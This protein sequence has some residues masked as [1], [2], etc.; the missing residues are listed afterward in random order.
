MAVDIKHTNERVNILV[1]CSNNLRHAAKL[2][3]D[4]QKYHD[5]CTDYANRATNVNARMAVVKSL[6]DAIANEL[7]ELASD[8]NMAFQ[9][10]WVAGRN[11]IEDIYVNSAT[12]TVLLRD[13]SG[14][15]IDHT[16]NNAL[17]AT[18]VIRLEGSTY[19]SQHLVVSAVTLVSGAVLLTTAAL[20][21]T[22]SLLSRVIKEL[23]G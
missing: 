6:I 10:E 7:T 14:V 22:E 17:S 11:G 5:N 13:G 18:D 1:N 20:N 3:Q 2:C 8:A 19:N 9:F 16:F 21:G 23:K 12:N 15:Q 4:V